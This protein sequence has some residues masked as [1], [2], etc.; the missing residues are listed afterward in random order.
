[1]SVTVS[2]NTVLYLIGKDIVEMII[3]QK[4]ICFLAAD[5]SVAQLWIFKLFFPANIVKQAGTNQ[6]IIINNLFSFRNIHSIVK[7]SVDMI[8]VVC[9]VTNTFKHIFF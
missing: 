4:T 1:M 7:H 9:A 3:S 8:L 5:H 2:L 6:Y